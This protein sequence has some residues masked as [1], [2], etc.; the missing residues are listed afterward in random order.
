MCLT[1]SF[2]IFGSNFMEFHQIFLKTVHIIV[3]LSPFLLSDY[4]GG[5]GL[6]ERPQT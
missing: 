2:L 3:E 5:V 4:V 1:E 6:G